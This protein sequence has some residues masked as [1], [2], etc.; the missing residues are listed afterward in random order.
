M[1]VRTDRADALVAGASCATGEV[2]AAAHHFLGQ[3]DEEVAGAY[4]AI[5]GGVDAVAF[6]A[7]VGEND[8]VVRAAVVDGLDF[9]GI[10]VDPA[11]NAAPA[12]GCR[13]ISPDAAPVAVL[14]V[15]TDEEMAIA[16][17]TMAVIEP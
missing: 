15:P 11:R 1:L 3:A 4:T 5:M 14:V 13:V 7:G 10:Q 16:A 17:D 2:V 6:A 8:S 12:T 9:L